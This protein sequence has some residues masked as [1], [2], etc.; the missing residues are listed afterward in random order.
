M[1]CIYTFEC[2]L[3]RV[4]LW[5]TYNYSN[6]LFFC[7]FFFVKNDNFERWGSSVVY[8]K[9]KKLGSV[10]IFPFLLMLDVDQSQEFNFIRDQSKEELEK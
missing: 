5:E 10:N 8:E 7:F 2:R 4:L 9:K 1:I 6:F 3:M